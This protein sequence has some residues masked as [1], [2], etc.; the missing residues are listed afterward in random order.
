MSKIIIPPKI[1]AF[2][3]K[4]I[5]NKRKG[6]AEQHGDL[7]EYYI[8]VRAQ[9]VKNVLDADPLRAD[10]VAF[11][12]SV[13][14]NPDILIEAADKAKFELPGEFEAVYGPIADK[15]SS[16]SSSKNRNLVE[17]KL[18]TVERMINRFHYLLDTTSKLSEASKPTEPVLSSQKRAELKELFRKNLL[19]VASK[20]MSE[21]IFQKVKDELDLEDLD[22]FQTFYRNL[23]G[24]EANPGREDRRNPII[25]GLKGEAAFLQQALS[26]AFVHEISDNM[27]R[28][29]Y[30]FS[31][32]KKIEL[33]IPDNVLNYDKYL[34][35]QREKIEEPKQENGTSLDPQQIA[36]IEKYQA[37]VAKIKINGI[38]IEILNAL[39][40]KELKEFAETVSRACQE[41]LLAEER[42]DEMIKEIK[43]FDLLLANILLARKKAQ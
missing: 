3:T 39:D 17:L 4:Y 12:A 6:I 22:T 34:G 30:L 42:G 1:Q 43:R 33:V 15:T 9:M 23:I 28:N 41:G 29:I 32:Q 21:N 26:Y 27:L 5:E 31:K 7:E 19:F 13:A 14:T 25:N 16:S 8:Q 10:I 38:H 18:Y 37:L 11:V 20:T 35:Y 24:T 40:R 36:E 2:G